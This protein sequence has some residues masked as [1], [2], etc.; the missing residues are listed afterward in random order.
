MAA[1]ISATAAAA[2]AGKSYWREADARHVVEAWRRSGQSL[3]RFAAAQGVKAARLARWAS[4]LGKRAVGARGHGSAGPAR[5]KLRFHPVELVGNATAFETSAIEVVLL[6][7][8]RVRV[9]AGFA[10]D[11]LERV[12]RVLEERSRC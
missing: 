10:S 1:G 12:L 8:R 3:S 7:G 9:A 2:A 11:D 6:D 5:L 4:R